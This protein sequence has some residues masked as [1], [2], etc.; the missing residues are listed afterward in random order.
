MDKQVNEYLFQISIQI[1][2][3][4]MPNKQRQ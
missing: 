1:A 3:I 2:L 4:L